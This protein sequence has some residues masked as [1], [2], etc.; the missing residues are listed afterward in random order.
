MSALL[1]GAKICCSI[2]LPNNLL[3]PIILKSKDLPKI[4]CLTHFDYFIKD[5]IVLVPHE[6]PVHIL[7][8][9]HW[10][11][12]CHENGVVPINLHKSAKAGILRIGILQLACSRALA[13]L[14]RRGIALSALCSAGLKLN[15]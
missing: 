9:Y 11:G 3:I 5:C 15:I 14:A 8:L 12:S 2:E 6:Y 13:R 4:L 7:H 10:M 1:G